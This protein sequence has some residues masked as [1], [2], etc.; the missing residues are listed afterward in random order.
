[1]NAEPSTVSDSTDSPSHLVRGCPCYR[2]FGEEKVCL[3]NDSVFPV[4]AISVDPSFFSQL[5]SRSLLEEFQSDNQSMCYLLMFLDR[6]EG[7]CYCVS[8]NQQICINEKGVKVSEIDSALQFVTSSEK[9]RDGV[10]CSDCLYRY[11][12]T[13]GES[14]EG[15]LTDDERQGIIATYVRELAT[16]MAK[17]LSGYEGGGNPTEFNNHLWGYLREINRSRS[18]WASMI[19]NLK[20]MKTE[21]D[22]IDLVDSYR[23]LARLESVFLFQVLSLDDPAD[24]TDP[25]SILRF[26]VGVSE[27]V[28]TVNNAIRER[29]NSL[30]ERDAIP[31]NIRE[32]LA[33]HSEA[34]KT[35]EYKFSN[36]VSALH[37]I[38]THAA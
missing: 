5:D 33:Q 35:T 37:N 6:E 2:E 29:T 3:N 13:L 21:E 38:D 9:S 14:S 16:N 4:N 32:M 30:V 1:M 15:F 18:H 27:K 28:I 19:L 12:R 34:R 22:L 7:F 36:L 20:K 23:T 26:M 17:Q 24:E 25:L 10:L 31:D 8:Q 11:L